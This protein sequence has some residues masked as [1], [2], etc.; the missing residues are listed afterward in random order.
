M[1]WRKRRWRLLLNLID[2]LPRNSYF[3]EALLNDEEFAEQ[4]IDMPVSEVPVERLSEWSPVREA[5]ARVE[6]AVRGVSV[7]VL[8]A[9]GAEPPSIAPAVRPI[10]A[11]DRARA[12]RRRAEHETLVSRVLPGRGD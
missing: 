10:T 1:L 8:A 4:V 7:A 2:H 12:R 11:A 3:V 5:L 6:D 9:A